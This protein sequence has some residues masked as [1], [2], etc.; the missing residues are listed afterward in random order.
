MKISANAKIYYLYLLI[1]R[2]PRATFP[3]MGRLTDLLLPTTEVKKANQFCFYSYTSYY[4]IIPL[5]R[6]IEYATLLKHTA[7]LNLPPY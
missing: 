1:R 3:D 6:L 7:I 5:Y 4:T 2:A